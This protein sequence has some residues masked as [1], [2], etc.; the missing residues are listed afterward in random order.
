MKEYEIRANGKINITLE[1]I[2]PRPDGYHNISTIM[3][4][5]K[6]HDMLRLE[7][8]QLGINIV[9]DDSRIP[10][11]RSN[12]AYRAV[13]KI[14]NKFNIKDGIRIVIKKRI[15]ISAGLG[16]GSA[17]AAACLKAMNQ[18]FDLKLSTEELMD[19]GSE[20][21]AD[22]P[23]CILG[24]AA[25]AEGKGDILTSLEGISP[26]NMIL[27]KPDISIST[28]WA[29]AN[30]KLK[31]ECQ[32]TDITELI[33]ALQKGNIEYVAANIRNTFEQ[34]VEAHYP[35]VGHAKRT[36]KQNGAIGSLMSGSGPTVFGL[37]TDIDIM[38]EAFNKITALGI[39][40]F[41]ES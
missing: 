35:E 11:D 37:Y 27:A 34:L 16:G 6:L 39:E 24:G 22:V 29:Y 25:L 23:F 7:K 31:N 10:T 33:K 36:L 15:P 26:L 1:V 13:E 40:C 18:L 20:I 14:R 12:L 4:S 21:G 30:L 17:D 32:K 41:T 3:Y 38:K 2:G 8:K 19:I 9:C 5:T 28:A